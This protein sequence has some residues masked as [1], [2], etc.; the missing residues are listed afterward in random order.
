LRDDI[1]RLFDHSRQSGLV[2]QPFTKI[3][4]SHVLFPA[5]LV[6]Q[7]FDPT[8][9][10]V[11]VFGFTPTLVQV[12]LPTEMGFHVFDPGLTGFHSSPNTRPV[13]VT[14]ALA[15]ICA[16]AAKVAFAVADIEPN[17][18]TCA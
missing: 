18:V 15:V 6:V 11:H 14:V 13:A 12:S 5:D 3:Y 10:S 2:R 7:V 8:G 1:E 4:A 9:T 17:A 16:D